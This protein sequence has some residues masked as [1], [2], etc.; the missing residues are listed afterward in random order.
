MLLNNCI[1]L[2]LK[3][4]KKYL[5]TIMALVVISTATGCAVGRKLTFENKQGGPGYNTSKTATVVFQ[6]KRK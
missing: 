6:D 4:M 3:V 2:N 1:I 5:N